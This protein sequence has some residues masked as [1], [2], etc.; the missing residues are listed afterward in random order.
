ME[1]CKIDSNPCNAFVEGKSSR[2]PFKN[3]GRRSNKIQLVHSDICGPMSTQSIGDAKYMLTFIDDYSRKKFVYFLKS[4]HEVANT[5]N[6]FKSLVEN[7]TGNK[8]KT[9]RTDN[10]TEY[11]NHTFKQMLERFG[12]VHQTTEPY[13][14]EHNGVAEKAN[15]TIVEMARTMLL[16][17]KLPR[18][19]W[20]EAVSTAVYLLN[21]CPTQ[22]LS[23]EVSD[24]AGTGIKPN[25]SHLKIFGC[26]AM[27]HIPKQTRDKW[28][29]PKAK[30]LLFMGYPENGKAYRLIDPKT[31]K[32][33]ISRNV[34]FFEKEFPAKSLSE[35]KSKPVEHLQIQ[36]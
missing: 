36:D 29:Y 26:E 1:Y 21:K 7:Q 5:F 18:K 23:N 2:L 11:V 6:K 30:K 12:I 31:G 16:E 3:Q 9:I 25:L 10:G 17:V 28:R 33:T 32:I 35:N 14:P 34:T 19:Y 8:L 24:E 27:V 4:K 22:V 20:A 13:T 15:R